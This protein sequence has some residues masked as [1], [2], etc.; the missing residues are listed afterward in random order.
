VANRGFEVQTVPDLTGSAWTPLNV[1]ANAPSFSATNRNA[2]ITDPAA[3]G[4]SGYYRVRI[5]EP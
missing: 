3:P 4:D 5:Y 2:L 1:P